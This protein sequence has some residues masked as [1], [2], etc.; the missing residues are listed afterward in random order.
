MYVDVSLTLSDGVAALG[1]GL[2]LAHAPLHSP[3][4]VNYRGSAGQ[5]FGVF[6]THGVSLTLDG[7]ANDYV[8]KGMEG[9]TIVVL[10]TGV[11]HEPAVGNA[12]FYGARGGEAFV[13]G[14][15][16]ERFAVSNRGAVLVVEGAGDHA[17]EY[18]T[19]GTVVL[20]GP[21][22]RNFASGMSGGAAFVLDG[23]RT[24]MSPDNPAIAGF[25]IFVIQSVA[26]G[27][28]VVEG[29]GPPQFTR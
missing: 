29:R 2:G 12:C 9:G 28:S 17:C 10:G 7:D 15:A 25:F 24:A 18:M 20:L 1:F 13:A 19:A 26:T 6:L 14:T 4:A 8:G 21:V 3:I 22:G 11:A 5:S 16:G 23:N 27:G